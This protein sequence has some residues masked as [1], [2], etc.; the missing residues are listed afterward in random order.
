MPDTRPFNRTRLQLA[1]S[2]L[3]LN[4]DHDDAF[5]ARLTTSLLRMGVNGCGGSSERFTISMIPLLLREVGG[6]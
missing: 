3:T 1:Q 4:S 2:P 5:L 6:E